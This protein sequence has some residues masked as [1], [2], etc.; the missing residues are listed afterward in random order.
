MSF[1]SDALRA[2][3]DAVPYVGGAFIE[4]HPHRLR[5]IAALAGIQGASVK[6]CRVLDIGCGTGRNIIPMAEAFPSSRFLGID[7]S[8][9]Q[10]EIGNQLI[11]RLGLK[12]IELRC[13][14]LMAFPF[15]EGPFDY[16]IAQGIYS[17][18]PEDVRRRLLE[19]C[20]RVL[21]EF[22]IAYISYNTLPGWHL[23]K[24]ARDLMNFHGCDDGGSSL[25]LTRAREILQFAAR[26][27]PG[28]HPY[29]EAM[30]DVEQAALHQPDWYFLHDDMAAINVPVY[31]KDFVEHVAGFA[32]AHLGDAHPT[33]DNLSLLSPEIQKDISRFAT[34]DWKREQYLDFLQGRAYRASVL[35]R[36][37]P[38]ADSANASHCRNLF[39]AGNLLEQPASTLGASQFVSQYTRNQI[40]VADPHVVRAFRKMHEAWPHAVPFADLLDDSSQSLIGDT[41]AMTGND[42]ANILLLAY[43]AGVIEIWSEPTN[44]LA[45]SLDRPRSTRLARLQLESNEPVVN[46]R[47]QQILI[48][49]A[50]RKFL[51]LMDGTKSHADLLF[52]LKELLSAGAIKLP[53]T[54]G[55]VSLHDDLELVLGQI[56]KELSAASLL[57][58]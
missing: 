12:N 42:L 21:A 52:T 2:G 1:E 51:P 37:R 15:T 18:V 47:H 3:Y 54:D 6:A 53:T 35:A 58:N 38:R 23:K 5:T 32:L 36:Q 45:K 55:F 7:L 14:D 10:I 31:F 30:K 22:G 33:S 4:T 24:A 16:I 57:Q 11:H 20:S 26:P 25:R 50:I 41:A 27:S 9:R 40:T 46:L 28:W 44:F 29:K 19:V 34:E 17:W 49:E 39:F 56:L 8:P 43:R 13:Q 48:T